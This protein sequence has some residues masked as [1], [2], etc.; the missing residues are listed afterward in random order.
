MVPDDRIGPGR[1]RLDDAKIAL[2]DAY[3]QTLNSN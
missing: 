3:R 2:F 1:S